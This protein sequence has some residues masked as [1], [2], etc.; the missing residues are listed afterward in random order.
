M[1]K[2]QSVKSPS[3]RNVLLSAAAAGAE[4]P[5]GYVDASSYGYNA[6]DAT[7][8]LQ[9]AINTGQNVFVPDMGTDW[10]INLDN[11]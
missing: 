4:I 8:A 9:A 2:S 10:F 3:R 5:P 11:K 6:T 1:P 7:A